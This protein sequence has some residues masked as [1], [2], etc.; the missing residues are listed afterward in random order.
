MLGYLVHCALFQPEA[1][2]A[3]SYARGRLS[4][5]IVAVVAITACALNGWLWYAGPPGSRSQVWA[6]PGAAVPVLVAGA[7]IWRRRHIKPQHAWSVCGVLCFLVIL[8][9]TA[10]LVPAWSNDR[11]PLAGNDDVEKQFRQGD[12]GVAWIGELWGS[13]RFRL[14]DD[15]ATFCATAQPREQ[16]TEFLTRY[17]RSY[18]ITKPEIDENLA[19]TLVGPGLRLERQTAST[20]AVIYLAEPVPGT[21]RR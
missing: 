6:I 20:R 12:V 16:L 2:R 9:S 8:E 15:Q 14:N 11:S 18:F 21:P 3:L 19:R 13:I 5:W 17:P 1:S 4:Y 10:I 7:M